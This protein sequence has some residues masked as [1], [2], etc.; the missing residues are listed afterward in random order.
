LVSH[1]ITQWIDGLKAG[2][3]AAAEELWQRYFHRLVG[4]A[5]QRLAGGPRRAA[6][7]EDVAI[8]AFKSL[9]TGAQRGSF[10]DLANRDNL[11]AVLVILT[12]RKTHDQLQHEH[13][14]RRGGGG[15]VCETDLNASRQGSLESMLA[16]EPTPELAA[17]LAEEYRLRLES[18]DADARAVAEHKMDGYSNEE[19]AAV[20]GC[21]LRT[22]ERKL[23]LIRRIWES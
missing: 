11:W 12:V 1:T 9:C 8:S 6:D 4:L 7:E 21:G 14:L 18:L 16:G 19:I 17:I 5:R 3:Q 13:R 22:V 10:P 2:E 20:L 15:V 23:A